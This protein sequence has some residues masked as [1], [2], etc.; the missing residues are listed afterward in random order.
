MAVEDVGV[1]GFDAV[2]GEGYLSL[3]GCLDPKAYGLGGLCVVNAVL[4]SL[5]GCESRNLCASR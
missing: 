1:F 2:D 5:V 4:E 3:N